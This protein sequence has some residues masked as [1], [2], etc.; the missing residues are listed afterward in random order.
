MTEEQLWVEGMQGQPVSL[1]VFPGT[2][3]LQAKLY[4]D[5]CRLP[6]ECHTHLG[7]NSTSGWGSFSLL[8]GQV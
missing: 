2:S 5:T 6:V 7:V 8:V 1:V 3:S 4:G